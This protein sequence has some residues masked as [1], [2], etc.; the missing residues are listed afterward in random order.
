MRRAQIHAKI[1]DPVRGH[2]YSENLATE[3]IERAFMTPAENME[4]EVE[5]ILED[6][7]RRGERR[8]D[9]RICVLP[10]GPLTIPYYS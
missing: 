10:E 5:R 4:H 7:L 9:F 1:C 2:F 6:H 8:E 3:D